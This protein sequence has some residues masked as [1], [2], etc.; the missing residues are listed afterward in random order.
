MPRLITI[1]LFLVSCAAPN[2][3]QGVCLYGDFIPYYELVGPVQDPIK[4]VMQRAEVIKC[5]DG[6]ISQK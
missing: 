1:F 3:N 5:V 4:E 2:Q 6:K